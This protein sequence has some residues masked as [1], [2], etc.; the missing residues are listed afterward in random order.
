MLQDLARYLQEKEDLKKKRRKRFV[1]WMI[2]LMV[3]LVVLSL[4]D[5]CEDNIS[6][7]IIK[8]NISEEAKPIDMWPRKANIRTPFSNKKQEKLFWAEELKK[9][10]SKKKAAI[11]R[12]L[13]KAKLDWTQWDF[14]FNPNTG[15]VLGSKFT[16]KTGSIAKIPCL[17][18]ILS[19]PYKLT[20]QERFNDSFFSIS[21]KIS[22]MIRK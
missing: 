3:L 6:K 15:R 16:D 8:P 21:L 2:L 11:H 17:L 4:I 5:T 20:N 7:D 14:E 10:V 1:G 13:D 12:C 9:L 18:P 22:Q 19:E